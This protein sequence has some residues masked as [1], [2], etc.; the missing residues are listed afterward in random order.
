MF[1]LVHQSFLFFPKRDARPYKSLY[2]AVLRINFHILSETVIYFICFS[3]R[4]YKCDVE[5][6]KSILE[7]ELY[8]QSLTTA[9]ERTQLSKGSI[10]LSPRPFPKYS[11]KLKEYPPKHAEAFIFLFFMFVFVTPSSSMNIGT[12]KL[13]LLVT[14]YDC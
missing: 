14:F 2:S 1:Y 7:A 13:G 6:I 11:S 10:T 4:L 5:K 9:I 3:C 12:C 8:Q